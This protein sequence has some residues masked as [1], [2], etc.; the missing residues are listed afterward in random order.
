[1]LLANM[2]VWFAEKAKAEE[3][4]KAEEEEDKTW[5]LVAKK[6]KHKKR[7]SKQTNLDL[8]SIAGQF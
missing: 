3:A 5:S 8:K 6:Y 1:M 7:N 2:S 4:A